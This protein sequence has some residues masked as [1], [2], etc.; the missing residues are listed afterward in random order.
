MKKPLWIDFVL[1]FFI[2]VLLT[3]V[4]SLLKADLEIEKW[5]YSPDAGWF[6][7]QKLPWTVLYDYG[8]IPALLLCLVG[9]LFFVMSFFQKAC[10]PYRKTGLFLVLVMILGPGLVINTAFKDHWGRPRPFD[11]VNFG[12][13]EQFRHVWEKG[14]SGM[15]KSFPSGH[16]SVGFFLFSPYFHPAKAFPKMGGLF[17]L[18][19]T[20]LWS[21]DGLRSN[22][23]GGA[24]YYGCYVVRLFYLFDGIDPF[25]SFSSESRN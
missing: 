20:F 8:M 1:P 2:I 13:V 14:Q 7:R 15:G 17:P 24:L 19:G 11:I 16:A 21:T 3:I 23:S 6:L 22:D 25:L 10:L 4:L 9:F 12:G 18:P 5:F